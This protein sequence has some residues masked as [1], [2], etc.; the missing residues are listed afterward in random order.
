MGCG[1]DGARSALDGSIVDGVTVA[2]AAAGEYTIV[3]RSIDNAG[4]VQFVVRKGAADCFGTTGLFDRYIVTVPNAYAGGVHDASG[5]LMLQHGLAND[6]Q[7]ESGSSGS[8]VVDI[9]AS[10][11]YVGSFQ[12]VFPS[13]NTISGDFRSTLC[14]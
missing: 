6:V 9:A 7:L 14:P 11:A 3:G 1:S 10:G 12:A 8:V 13:G 2:G 4:T 5:G